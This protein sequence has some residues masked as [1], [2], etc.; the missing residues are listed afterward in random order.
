MISTFMMA[1]QV[2]R[3]GESACHDGQMTAIPDPAVPGPAEPG[4]S[5]ALAGYPVTP[6]PLPGPVTFDQRWVTDLRPLAG[7]ARH[8]RGP[9]PARDPTRRLRRRDHLCGVGP[10][11]HESTKFA[12]HFHFRTSAA[13]RRPTSGCT[14]LTTPAGTASCSGRWKP[15]GWPL[16]RHPDRPRRPLHLGEDADEPLGDRI[17]Y[18]SVRRWPH[19]GLRSRMRSRRRRGRTDSA[20]SLAYRPMGRAHPQSRPD[21]V[22]TERA[23]TWPLR[24]ATSSS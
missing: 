1:R 18:H 17:T 10:V 12:P 11:C 23:R 6:P 16:C 19:R 24:A 15:L 20:G 3:V 5:P 21:L 9:V 8:R 7:A 2:Q 4:A 22:D 14:P 13:S